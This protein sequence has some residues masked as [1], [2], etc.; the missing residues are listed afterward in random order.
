MTDFESEEPPTRARSVIQVVPLQDVA[1]EDVADEDVP[2]QAVRPQ[3]VP[4][5][6]VLYRELQEP[7]DEDDDGDVV[8]PADDDVVPTPA[9]ADVVTPVNANVVPTPAEDKVLLL[10]DAG[11]LRAEWQSIRAGFIDDPRGSVAEAANV[12]EKAVEM[13]VAALRAEQ[14]QVRHS[15][16]GDAPGIDTE[17]MR[18]ALLTY[19][20]LFNRVAGQ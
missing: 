16:D 14:D 9:D 10:A 3:A 18:Q 11:Y 13:L 7:A 20:S 19:Q 12:V 8:T 4:S 2:F 15:W 1:D 5:Q 17:S 6:A